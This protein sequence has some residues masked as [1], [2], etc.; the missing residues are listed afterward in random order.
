VVKNNLSK[1][2][3]DG[4]PMYRK[5]GKLLKGDDFIKLDPDEAAGFTD[6]L[7]VELEAFR[8]LK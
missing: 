3:K 6:K 7:K 8:T 4:K 1:L 2:G 5:D